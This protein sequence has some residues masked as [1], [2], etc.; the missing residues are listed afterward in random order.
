M[1]ASEYFLAMILSAAIASIL[2][3]AYIEAIY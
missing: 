1:R 2:A 3:I